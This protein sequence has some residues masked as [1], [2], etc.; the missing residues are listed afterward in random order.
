M[1]LGEECSLRPLTNIVN[2]NSRIIHWFL[3]G[4][5]FFRNLIQFLTALSFFT[6]FI[7]FITLVIVLKFVFILAF[8]IFYFL[9]KLLILLGLV[10]VLWFWR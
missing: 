10:S 7:L 6:N 1:I 8:L 2:F 9:N 4:L 5:T 3:Q